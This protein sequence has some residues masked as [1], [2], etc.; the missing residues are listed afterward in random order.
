MGTHKFRIGESVR[1]LS[2]GAPQGAYVII[3]L[4]SQGEDGAFEYRI[5]DSQGHHQTSAKESEL[6]AGRRRT[7]TKI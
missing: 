3:S 7:Y 6:T 2:S 5:R 1:Y 4:L